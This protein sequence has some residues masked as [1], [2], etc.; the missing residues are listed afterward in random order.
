MPVTALVTPGPEVTRATPTLLGRAR[1][2]VGGMHRALLVAHQHVAN[3]VL[4]EQFVV[5]E[6]NGTAGIAE[7]VFDLFFL[8]APDYN[9]RTRQN[10]CCT[11]KAFISG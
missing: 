9:F 1:I 10:H 4:L 11:R 6:Q 7:N 8:Q 3:L 5:N 2:T